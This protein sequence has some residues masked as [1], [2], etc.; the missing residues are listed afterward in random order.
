MAITQVKQERPGKNWHFYLISS[1]SIMLTVLA[2]VGAIYFRE[3]IQHL[4]GYGY[5]G[6]FVVG[7]LC[8]ISIIPAPTLLMVFT[9]GH[10]LNPVYVG[11]VAGVGG[12]LGGITVYLT[13]AGAETIWSRLQSRIRTFEYQPGSEQD[14]ERP[15]QTKLWSKGGALYNRIVRWIGGRGGSWTLF[16]TS[17]MVISPFYFAG[18]A[19]GSLRTGLLRFF[20]ISWAGKTVR[21]L[22]VAFAGYWGLRFLLKWVGA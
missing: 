16:I 8:G 1:I 14:T 17:A 5:L 20:L 6:V 7:V 3:E 22:T 18:I 21:Y 10:V 15:I 12:A 19:A 13:G 2:V 11:L 4:Q 9:L